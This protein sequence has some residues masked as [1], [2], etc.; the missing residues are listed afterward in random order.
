METASATR[1]DSATAPATEP[2]AEG[3]AEPMPT[4][5]PSPEAMT[6]R[7]EGVTQPEGSS[8]DADAPALFGASY[9]YR[10]S[11][12]SPDSVARLLRLAGRYEGRV[13]DAEGHV[14][15]EGADLT[16]PRSLRVQIPARHLAAFGDALRSLG[17][18]NETPDDRIFASSQVS[19]QVDL[20]P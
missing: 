6:R 16:S 2:M 10:V 15:T 18:V 19:I 5:S 9:R 1:A 12:A 8:E 13:V 7:T 20:V 4:P 3:E 11:S 14:V 17:L